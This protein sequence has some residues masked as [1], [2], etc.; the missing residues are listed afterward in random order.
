MYV[1]R[2]NKYTQQTHP[3]PWSGVPNTLPLFCP[4]GYLK[5]IYGYGLVLLPACL[6]NVDVISGATMQSTNRGVNR[7]AI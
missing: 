1:Q 5:Y 7:F 3:T 2:V 6:P 4:C